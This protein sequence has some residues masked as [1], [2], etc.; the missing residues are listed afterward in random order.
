MYALNSDPSNS[1]SDEMPIQ[2]PN[3]VKNNTGMWSEGKFTD[4][5]FIL[6]MRYL[7]ANN[8]MDL[9]SQYLH[10]GLERQVPSWVKTVA[11]WWSTGHISDYEFVSSI[12]YL[13]IKGD[14]VLAPT[15]NQT[16][17]QD[18][19]TLQNNFPKGRIKID[20]TLLAV[21]IA[22][23]SDR[24]TEGLQFQ[25]PLPYDHGMIFVFQQPQIVSMWMKDMQFPLDMIW[26]DSNGDVI[27]IEKNLTP[28]LE[29]L[30]CSVYNGGGQNT[31]YVLEVTAGFVDKF[32]VTTN[33][34]MVILDNPQ[35]K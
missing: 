25:Q 24:M 15:D 13:I 18:S 19:N 17:M 27:H 26:F 35:V 6:G 23:T 4:S 31:K 8:I 5:Q 9:P 30:P 3:W 22:D 28:C 34:K 11:A 21:Q 16:A 29:N 32:N 2:V 7:A 1:Y 33:S 10:P 14:I 12:Q 20:E